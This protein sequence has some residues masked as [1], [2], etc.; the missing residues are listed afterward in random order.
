MKLKIPGKSRIQKF[1]YIQVIV[2]DLSNLP[3]AAVGSKQVRNHEK[4]VKNVFSKS[5][6]LPL[7]AKVK[8]YNLNVTEFLYPAFSRNFQLHRRDPK[9]GAAGFGFDSNFGWAIF[10]SIF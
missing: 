7:V 4:N 2:F 10:G 3:V 8:N 9:T 5:Q 6:P 1:R